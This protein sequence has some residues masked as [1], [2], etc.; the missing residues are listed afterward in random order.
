[1]NSNEL[2]L[3]IMEVLSNDNDESDSSQLLLNLLEEQDW[4]KS[5]PILFELLLDL[6]QQILWP[7][8]IVTLWY[9]I[10]NKKNLPI[11]YTIAV[12]HH[13]LTKNDSIDGNL[14]WSITRNLKKVAYDSDYDP[15]QDDG[16]WKILQEFKGDDK[17]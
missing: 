11:D 1:M 2:K 16:V 3:K 17:K 13:C 14:V 9:A 8:I 15:Y 10:G 5:Y 4:E 12:M 7:Q 6:N